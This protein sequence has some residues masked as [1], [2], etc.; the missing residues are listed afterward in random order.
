M[1]TLTQSGRDLAP[2]SE[3]RANRIRHKPWRKIIAYAILVP[4][5]FGYVFPFYWMVSTSLKSDSEIFRWPP[6]LAPSILQ[7]GNYPAAL[8][9]IP[10][11]RYMWNTLVIAGLTVA[12]TVAS[13]AL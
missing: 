13:S 4:M 2:P 8:T 7:L 3:Q 5:A 9:Y 11:F 6:V 12:G 1:A 10:F